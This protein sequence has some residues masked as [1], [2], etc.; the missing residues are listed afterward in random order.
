MAMVHL[1]AHRMGWL[2]TR[3]D[4]FGATLGRLVDAEIRRVVV[5]KAVADE[6][7]IEM[8]I[9]RHRRQLERRFMPEKRLWTRAEMDRSRELDDQADREILAACA[10]MEDPNTRAAA[11]RVSFKRLLDRGEISN[12]HGR[13]RQELQNLRER[14]PGGWE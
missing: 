2:R 11:E 14:R 8:L 9:R 3:G 1:D 7:D 4:D 6:H 10:S 13:G 5:K 12:E